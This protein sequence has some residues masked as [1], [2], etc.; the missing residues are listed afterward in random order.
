MK[1]IIATVIVVLVLVCVLVPLT[2]YHSTDLT[3]KVV[4][5]QYGAC[6]HREDCKEVAG[7]EK[8][9]ITLGEASDKGYTP[10]GVCMR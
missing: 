3:E 5:T 8:V 7:I 10:C 1:K 2:K 9:Y 6:Y 4:I